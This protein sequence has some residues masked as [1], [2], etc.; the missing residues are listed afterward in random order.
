MREELGI[1]PA[2]LLTT[3]TEDY[4]RVAEL[5]ALARAD[6]VLGGSEKPPGD[7]AAHFKVGECLRD[8]FRRLGIAVYCLRE[9]PEPVDARRDVGGDDGAPAGRRAVLLLKERLQ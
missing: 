1:E 4:G 6:K 2:A 8:E 5:A 3:V 9:W 7:S